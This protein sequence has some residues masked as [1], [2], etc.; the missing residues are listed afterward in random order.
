[1]VSI[2]EK[3]EKIVRRV[4]GTEFVKEVLVR[5]EMSFDGEPTLRIRVVYDDAKGE[6]DVSEMIAVIDQLWKITSSEKDNLFPVT[7]FVSQADDTREA[8]AA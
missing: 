8:A 3:I 7:D 4:M 2:D 6:P 5:R 1:M